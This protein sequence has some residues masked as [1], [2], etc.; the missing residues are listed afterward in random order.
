MQLYSPVDNNGLVDEILRITGTTSTVYSLKSMVARL[1]NA[2]DRY[3]F[4]ASSSAPKGTFDDVNN[5]SLPV[6]T[7]N[8][9]AG[10]N[11]YKISSFTNKVLE[12]SKL[13]VLND[14]GEEQDLIREDFDDLNQFY[15]LYNTDTANRGIPGYWTKMGDYIYVRA[16]PDYS[17]TSGLR[18]Y[19][20]RELSKFTWV[21]FTVTVAT[22]AVFTAI[23]HGLS[24]LD[25][26]IF[27]TDGAL[28]T[29]LTADTVVYYKI[30]AGATADAFEV[31]TAYSLTGTAVNTSVSQ[32]GNHKYTKVN[33][34]PGIPVIHHEYLAR[35]GALPFL[36]EKKLPQMN[37]IAQLINKDEQQ[38]MEYWQN[39]DK[40]LDMIMT[41][42]QRPFK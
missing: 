40:D 10:T 8:I 21:P 14:D 3:W 2:L 41:R 28:P 30:T 29:G 1:N 6:E 26:L 16:C 22:P 4:L 42:E 31:S 33:K 36:I 24:G 18:A 39:R 35:Q 20:N 12:I 37:A 11:A 23:G 38:I 7:Q 17:E 32:S 25:G 27:E 13:A 34:E 19:V 15:E 9:V 5:T